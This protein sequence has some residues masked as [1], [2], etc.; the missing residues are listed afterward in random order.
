MA[1]KAIQIIAGGVGVSSAAP[2]TAG[3]YTIISQAVPPIIT[4]GRLAQLADAV[5]SIV[6][7]DVAAPADVTSMALGSTATTRGAATSLVIGSAVKQTGAAAQGVKSVLMG[8][9]IDPG[10]AATSRANIVYIGWDFTLTDGGSAHGSNVFIGQNITTAGGTDV[11]TSVAIGVALTI[12]GGDN[13]AIGQGVTASLGES[14]VIGMSATGPGS[15]SVGIG[16]TASGGT[17]SVA[18]GRR[19]RA[20]NSSVAIGFFCDALGTDQVAVGRDVSGAF[21]NTVAIGRAATIGANDSIAIGRS[22]ATAVANQCVIGSSAS[23]INLCVIGAGGVNGTPD[24][25][26]L[27][28]SAGSGS[29]IAGWSFRLI[30]GWG[31][32]NAATGGIDLQAGVAGASGTTLQTA[33]TALAIRG[34]ALNVTLWGGLGFNFQGGVR[35]FHIDGA[36]VTAPTGNPAT[37]F[38]LFVD[39]ADGKLKARGTAGTITQLA[40]P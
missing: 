39:P 4:A 23:K 30:G 38:Y 18:V 28:P 5:Q 7:P 3:N 20:D 16:K 32:G 35:V 12:L 22:A 10:A 26:E 24:T 19:A 31:T 9:N 34:G 2:F 8:G 37:G 40:V 17:N 13:V 21:T 1:G 14:V 25:L 6:A 11:G 15:Q 29:D 33:T 27:R 36:N